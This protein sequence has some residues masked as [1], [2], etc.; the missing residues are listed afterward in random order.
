MN[1]ENKVIWKFK[2]AIKYELMND[3]SNEYKDWCS[4]SN[5]NSFAESGNLH[6]KK[7]SPA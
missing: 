4:L 6:I 1:F 2:L 5:W 7:E 3:L